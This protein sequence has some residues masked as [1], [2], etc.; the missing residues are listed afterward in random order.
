MKFDKR[1]EIREGNENY[2]G[3]GIKFLAL[4]FR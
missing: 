3:K 1:R 2:A 4:A